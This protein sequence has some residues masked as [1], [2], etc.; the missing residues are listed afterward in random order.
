MYLEKSCN[1]F[2]VVNSSF[3][4]ANVV[5]PRHATKKKKRGF[6]NTDDPIPSFL[7]QVYVNTM[8][9]LFNM[10]LP[11]ATMLSMNCLIYRAMNRPQRSRNRFSRSVNG[12]GSAANGHH[13]SRSTSMPAA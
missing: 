6:R 1:T 13:G 5:P 4:L 9:L 7:H 10:V 8:N 12:G 2:K 11:F 3:P